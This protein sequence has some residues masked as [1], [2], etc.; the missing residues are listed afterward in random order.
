MVL[1]VYIYLT[2]TNVFIITS[3]MFDK[4]SL[5]LSPINNDKNHEEFYLDVMIKTGRGIQQDTDKCILIGNGD[6]IWAK[7][8]NR[9]KV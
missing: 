9:A 4:P 1:Y 7:C 5:N 8:M 3:Y 2:K 6:M